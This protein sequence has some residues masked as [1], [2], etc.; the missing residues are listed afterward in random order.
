[1]KTII[2]FFL[3]FLIHSSSFSA[4]RS[5]ELTVPININI[6]SAKELVIALDGIGNK[7]ADAIIA[8]RKAVG[9]FKAIDELTEV[10][11]IGL[12]L[13]AQNRNRI[14]LE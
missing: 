1:M 11:G 14:V 8:Y 6:A 5:T 13:I 9:G 4:E 12:A 2:S 10:K 3:L 7:K